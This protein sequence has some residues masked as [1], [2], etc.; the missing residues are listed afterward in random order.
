MVATD[1]RRPGPGGVPSRFMYM[2][3]G[4]GAPFFERLFGETDITL[5]SDQR[6]MVDWLGQGQF[7]IGVF[8]SDREVQMAA[9]QG[10]PVDVMPGGRFKEGAPIG[11]AYGAVA[12]IDQAPH[13][14][15]AKVYTNWLLSWQGQSAWQREIEG[16]SLRIDVAKDGLPASQIPQ[17]G[18]DYVDAGTEEYARLTPS[19]I[20][21]LITQALVKG[22]RE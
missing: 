1:I 5:S 8:M 17:P 21:D 22:G 6:Q 15:A 16:P 20:R 19:I 12:L 4:L 9:Q 11:P 13:P 18:V 3:P 2:Q 7:P 14:N 10:L